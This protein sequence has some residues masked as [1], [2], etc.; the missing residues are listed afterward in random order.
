[1]H[2]IE[3][4]ARI[5]QQVEIFHSSLSKQYSNTKSILMIK[6][7]VFM[8]IIQFLA[9]IDQQVES[10]HSS[11][12]KQYSN[13]RSKSIIKV[14]LFQANNIFFSYDRSASRKPSF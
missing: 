13:I 8:Q 1:M 7:H 6:L 2:E 5:E 14:H 11:L 4:L 3:F 12:S 10:F 9:R